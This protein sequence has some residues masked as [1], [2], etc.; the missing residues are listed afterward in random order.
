[1]EW[2]SIIVQ[3]LSAVGSF[4]LEAIKA[5][6]VDAALDRP[7]REILPHELRSEVAKRIADEAA[8]AKFG[9]AP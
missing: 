3:I 8:A 2:A 7:L 5:G 6:S 4:V 1:M 9:T